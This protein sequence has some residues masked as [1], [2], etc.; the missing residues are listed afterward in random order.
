M[1]TFESNIS[2]YSN[3]HHTRFQKFRPSLSSLVL[4]LLEE[5]WHTLHWN[6]FV[7]AMYMEKG[8]SR[9]MQKRPDSS[10]SSDIP[11]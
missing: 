11:I 10:S 9:A 3:E 8:S 6:H 4:Q 5:L 1:A 2:N 7:D